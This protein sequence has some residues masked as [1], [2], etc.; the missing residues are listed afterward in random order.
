MAVTT[1]P[2]TVTVSAVATSCKINKKIV[3]KSD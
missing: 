2:I 3:K 1:R